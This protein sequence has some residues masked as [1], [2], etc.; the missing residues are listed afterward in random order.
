MLDY[1]KAVMGSPMKVYVG[2]E[3]INHPP[4]SKKPMGGLL[5]SGSS[6]NTSLYLMK[7]KLIPLCS[8]TSLKFIFFDFTAGCV[9]FVYLFPSLLSISPHPQINRSKRAENVFILFILL[10]L[11]HSKWNKTAV[12]CMNE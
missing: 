12:E 11:A 6:E 4:P 2:V 5:P 9:I 10:F 8:I 7:L 3:E 1:F